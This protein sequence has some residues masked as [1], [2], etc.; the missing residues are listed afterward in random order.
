MGSEGL[1][2][3][4]VPVPKS[5]R[6]QDFDRAPQQVVAGIAED[7]LRHLVGKPDRP[8][9]VDQ[10]HRI[11]Q[12]LQHLACTGVCESELSHAVVPRPV[13]VANIRKA[14]TRCSRWP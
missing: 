3:V 4:D 8:A 2:L 1:S 9:M 11:R 6:E 10:E 12:G 14:K 5:F 13:A 7:L